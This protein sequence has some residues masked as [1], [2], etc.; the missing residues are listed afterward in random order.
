MR[1][2]SYSLAMSRSRRNQQKSLHRSCALESLEDRRLLTSSAVGHFLRLEASPG[3][4]HDISGNISAEAIAAD[5]LDYAVDP[6]PG[7]PDIDFDDE[8][9]VREPLFRDASAGGA[10]AHAHAKMAGFIFPA[11]G[12]GDWGDEDDTIAVPLASMEAVEI[13]IAQQES[14]GASAGTSHEGGLAALYE[15][16]DP[17]PFVPKSFY[18]AIY[19]A[20]IGDGQALGTLS[21]WGTMQVA[22][23]RIS[24]NDNPIGN[25]SVVKNDSSSPVHVITVSID[26]QPEY[27]F[28]STGANL[29]VN[30]TTGIEQGDEI[31]FEISIGN[32]SGGSGALAQNVD[33]GSSSAQY[34]FI[35]TATAYGFAFESGDPP[36]LPPLWDGDTDGDPNIFHDGLAPGDLDGDGDVD[37][38]DAAAWLLVRKEVLENDATP[39]IVTTEEDVDDGDYSFPDLSLREAL[40]LADTSSYPGDDTIVFAKWVDNILL[41]GAH[42]IADSDVAIV[43]PGADKLTVDAQSNSRVFLIDP[44][45][46]AT[47]RGLT[48]T[49]GYVPSGVGGEGGGIFN[50]GDLTLDYVTITGNE[51]ASQGGGVTSRGNGSNIHASLAIINSTI[52]DNTAGYAGGVHAGVDSGETLLIQGTTFSNNE[53]TADS[54]ALRIQGPGQARVVNSTFS[55][56]FAPVFGAVWVMSGSTDVAFYNTTIAYNRGDVGGGLTQSVAATTHNTIIAENRNYAN[57]ADNDVYGNV[58]TASSYNLFGRGGSGGKSH[59]DANK[60]LVLSTGQN[61]GLAALG[62]FGGPTRTHALLAA[63][64]ALEKGK[65]LYAVSVDQRGGVRPYDFTGISNATGGDGSDIGAYEAGDFTTLTVRIDNDRLNTTLLADELSL[66]EALELAD[67][68]TGRETITFAPSLYESGPATILLTYLG[69]DSFV[70]SLTIN[71]DLTI[72]GPGADELI[73]DGGDDVGVIY[74]T[75]GQVTIEGVTIT[76]GNGVMGG[77]IRSEGDLTLRASRITDNRAYT[78]GG[79]ISSFGPLV[80][81]DSEISDN[82]LGFT[83]GSGGGIFLYQYDAGGGDVA[84]VN[85]TI[86]GNLVNGSA[87]KGGGIFSYMETAGVRATTIVNSTIA[88]NRAGIGGGLYSAVSSGSAAHVELHNTI[89]A[90]NLDVVSSTPDD[91]G[92]N[93]VL[94]TSSYNLIGLGGAGGLTDND[95]GNIVLT[96]SES[97]RLTALGFYGGTTRTHGLYSDSPA[98]NAGEDSYAE[99]FDLVFDQRGMERFDGDVDIGA[100]EL[101]LFE[102]FD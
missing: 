11:N 35:K 70:D 58:A 30:F 78:L 8:N 88:N 26:G 52:H 68:L 50:W 98:I 9:Q 4:D 34:N 51:A 49:G 96:G 17:T 87:S 45:V 74:H 40:A 53:G 13:A 48:V 82:S 31:L 41:D 22:N 23:V 60:N 86:S 57:T 7:P 75:S 37:G 3:A 67:D 5:G 92:G 77:G 97:A 15:Y 94:G 90:D 1:K 12:D 59:N 18:G 32:T 29:Y 65:N 25:V 63:S 84:I 27:E 91:I 71:S 47:I 93:N 6:D 64:P 44:G 21:G 95:D 55:G 46:E 24:K 42:L 10:N 62:D 72:A 76:Q 79:G 102:S 19:I 100:L 2:K 89:V 16:Q 61:A 69:G 73:I 33:E 38:D 80:V 66:R 28:E 43:G 85:S 101:G 83:G 39:L 56:N 14:G 20:S 81:I 54:G 99:E 36:V